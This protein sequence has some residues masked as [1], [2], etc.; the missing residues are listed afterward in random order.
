MTLRIATSEDIHTV[1]HMLTLFHSAS[2]YKDLPMD[3]NEVMALITDVINS[4]NTEKI[5]LLKY[6]DFGPVGMVAA[7]AVRFAITGHRIAMELA[8]WVQ[9]DARTLHVGKELLDAYEYWAKNVA[10]C[11]H[12]RLCTLVNGAEKVLDRVYKKRGYSPL[13]N[14]YLKEL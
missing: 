8:W 14:N 12:S 3:E 9:P 7:H 13:E 4:P 5:I 1:Y 2:P 11:T 6:D 10:N